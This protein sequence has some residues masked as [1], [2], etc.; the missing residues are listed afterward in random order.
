M[1]EKEILE[2]AQKNVAEKAFISEKR[3]REMLSELLAQANSD[4]LHIYQPYCV[5][6]TKSYLHLHKDLETA[7]EGFKRIEHEAKH[8]KGDLHTVYN[9]MR[10]ISKEA[11][12]A[13]S[14]KTND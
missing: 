11:L 9:N 4:E 5:E 12:Q 2:L 6:I 8:G 10:R 1:N 7:K 13:I 3:L 14:P